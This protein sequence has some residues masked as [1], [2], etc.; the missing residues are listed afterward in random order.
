M[1][2]VLYICVN[3]YYSGNPGPLNFDLCDLEGDKETG[4]A[5]HQVLELIFSPE[6]ALNF[7]LPTVEYS[8]LN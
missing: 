1:Y 8:L 6:K 3:N 2:I 5:G 7:C 4:P